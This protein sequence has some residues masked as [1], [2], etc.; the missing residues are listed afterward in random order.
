MIDVR[1]DISELSSSLGRASCNESSS[2]SSNAQN[3][4]PAEVLVSVYIAQIAVFH[5]D[6]FVC[7]FAINH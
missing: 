5:I 7:N 1:N 6:H 4:F 3:N 2:G